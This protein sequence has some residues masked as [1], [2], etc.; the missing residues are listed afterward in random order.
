MSH[1]LRGARDSMVPPADPPPELQ[2]I[3]RYLARQRELRGITLDELSQLTRIPL[4]SLHRLESGA[5]DGVADGFV[6][7]FVR[8]VAEALGLDCEDAVA[9]MLREQ[10]ADREVQPRVTT[11]MRR[12]LLCVSLVLAVLLTIGAVRAVVSVAVPVSVEVRDV[13]FRRNAV[14][15]LAVEQRDR[16]FSFRAPPAADD[17]AEAT[18][19]EFTDEGEE[20]LEEISEPPPPAP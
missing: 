2:S 18:S 15:L 3:G 20:G 7:G 8:S 16:A 12:A 6:R 9:R 5:Y 14:R 10:V 1:A 17:P 19:E 13:V 4:R 11:R